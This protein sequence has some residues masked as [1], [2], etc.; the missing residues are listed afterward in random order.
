MTCDLFVRR[1]EV[2]ITEYESAPKAL[3]SKIGHAYPTYAVD[4]SML[5][6]RSGGADLP[7]V[8]VP[9]IAALDLGVQASQ[10]SLGL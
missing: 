2:G 10:D 6:I 4:I 1:G 7:I 8:D 3:P 9:V 5:N